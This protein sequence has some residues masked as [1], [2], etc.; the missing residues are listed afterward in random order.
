MTI[1]RQLACSLAIAALAALPLMSG[2]AAAQ[3]KAST[4]AYNARQVN[5]LM[6]GRFMACAGSFGEDMEAFQA[7]V[8]KLYEKSGYAEAE[9]T[10][11][12]TLIKQGRDTGEKDAKKNPFCQGMERSH[13]KLRMNRILN[14]V[15]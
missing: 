14:P 4:P 5:A 1:K 13:I 6:V 10:E 9:R 15:N 7:D 11:L 12:E 3:K 2:P 8:L